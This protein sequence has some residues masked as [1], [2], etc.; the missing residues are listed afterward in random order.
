MEGIKVVLGIML[1]LILLVP[2]MVLE[3]FVFVFGGW[4]LPSYERPSPVFWLM[5]ILLPQ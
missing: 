2:F 3:A 1:F 5:D 4:A